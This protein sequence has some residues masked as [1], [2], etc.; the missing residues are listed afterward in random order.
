[1]KFSVIVLFCI[2]FISCSI[3]DHRY[4]ISYKSSE[5]GMY[6]HRYT[7]S[8]VLKDGCVTFTDIENGNTETICGSFKITQ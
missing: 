4:T 5:N 2:F 6:E 3:P 1:M 8:Y 7:N